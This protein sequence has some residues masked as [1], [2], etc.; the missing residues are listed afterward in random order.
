MDFCWLLEHQIVN[1]DDILEELRTKE[2]ELYE[3]ALSIA[4]KLHHSRVT[5][6]LELERGVKE[7]LEFLDMPK[8]VF[9]AKI[10][11]C[12]DGERMKLGALGYDELEFYISANLGADALPMCKIASGGELARVMLALKG[13]IA[14]KDGVSTVIFDEIDAGVSGKTAR[15]IGVKMRELAKGAQII[16]VTHSAQIASL[17]DVHLLIS[18]ETVDNMTETHV[19]ELDFDGRVGELSRILGGINVTDAQ[20]LAAID[21]LNYRED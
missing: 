5:H 20:R 17:A 1:S 12:Q 2:N 15:K 19:R 8:V 9:F 10:D 21:M 11:A 4:D 16:C 7:T 3:A 6:S 14:D 13:V 18:K